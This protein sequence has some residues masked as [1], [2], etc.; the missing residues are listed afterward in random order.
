MPFCSHCGK[1]VSEDV[2]FCP[3]CGKRLK[4]GD[5]GETHSRRKRGIVSFFIGLIA[6]GAICGILFVIEQ[7]TIPYD[8]AVEIAF[9]KAVREMPYALQLGIAREKGV[10]VEE[11]LTSPYDAWAPKVA[12]GL[13]SAY[14]V[15]GGI[16]FASRSSKP[17]LD[18]EERS[19]ST[20]R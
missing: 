16:Y 6:V 7:A 4:L 19:Q 3:H 12:I 13:L 20:S 18:R 2:S 1:E 17:P 15:A 11:L 14:V 5:K 8:L 10:T 9:V